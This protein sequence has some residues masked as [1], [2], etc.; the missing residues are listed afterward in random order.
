[1]RPIP[2]SHRIASTCGLFFEIWRDGCILGQCAMGYHHAM[3]CAGV[4]YCAS[5]VPDEKACLSF[6]LVLIY[7]EHFKFGMCT[8]TALSETSRQGTRL[9]YW[10]SSLKET[11]STPYR[12]QTT[13]ISTIE[14]RIPLTYLG[15]YTQG[16]SAVYDS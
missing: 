4:Q 11:G 5:V 2:R 16:R 3:P 1:M 15:I 6:C 10:C 7:A 9:V 12:Q 13:C 14:I 8:Y